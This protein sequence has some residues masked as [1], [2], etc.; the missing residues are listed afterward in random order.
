MIGVRYRGIDR[1]AVPPS[2]KQDILVTIHDRMNHPG[3]HKTLELIAARYWWPNR[4]HDVRFHVKTLRTCQLIKPPNVASHGHLHPVETPDAPNRV[5]ALDTIVIGS[6]A[7][8]TVKKYVITAVDHHS[9]YR[10]AVAVKNNTSQAVVNFLT[11]LFEPVGQPKTIL[12]DNGTNY[13]SKQLRKFLNDRQI[14]H[15]FSPPYRPQANGLVEKTNDSLITGIR[16]ALTDKPSMKWAIALNVVLQS[17]NDRSHDV[18][19][20]TPRYLQ[21]GHTVDGHPIPNTSIEDARRLATQR[22]R[23]AQA[24]RAEAHASKHEHIAYNVGDY[25]KYRLAPNHPTRNKFSPYFVGPCHV[26]ERIGHETYVLDELDPITGEPTRRQTIHGSALDRYYVRSD[27]SDNTNYTI[28]LVV[29]NEPRVDLPALD[30][31]SP[32][33]G[34]KD[35]FRPG[36]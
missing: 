11:R 18:T 34:T 2:A 7:R 9:R 25:V 17:I 22:S 28:D 8:D 1:I 16:L 3:Y 29:D 23:Q 6:A 10:W 36:N 19:G 13:S 35:A 31:T 26:V 4:D 24:K 14:R 27:A 15:I 30:T 21:F 5:W 32:T 12:V 33:T 20:F